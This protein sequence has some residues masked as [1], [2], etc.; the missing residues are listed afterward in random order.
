MAPRWYTEP[1]L[2]PSPRVLA[3]VLFALGAGAAPAWA[4][5]LPYDAS[6]IAADLQFFA[7]G[8]GHVVAVTPGVEVDRRQAFYGDGKRFHRL[9]LSRVHLEN[10]KRLSWV[11]WDNRLVGHVGKITVGADRGEVVCADRTTP[12]AAVAAEQA[13]ALL[14][15]AAFFDVRWQRRAYALARDDDGLYYHVDRALKPPQSLDFRLFV[16]R[17]GALKAQK[18][19]NVVS[20]PAGDILHTK[21][22]AL[23]I[24]PDHRTVAW[25]TKGKRA[26]AQPLVAID[27]G[28]SAGT[29]FVYND[30]GVYL[31][32]PLGTPCD[33]L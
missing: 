29:M 6:A 31:A 25:L 18:L 22:G 30:L 3:A 21:S 33:D 1:V 26:A 9:E 8:K 16:G 17:R 11:F 27:L 13:R 15:G 7:D 24:S 10:D 12:L 23:R 28:S 14:D 2:P 32:Q 19:T 5:D 4:D 20:D